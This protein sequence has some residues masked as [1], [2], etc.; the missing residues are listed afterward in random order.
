M[1]DQTVPYK[2]NE[3]SDIYCL[4]VLFWELTS[5][6]FINDLEDNHIALG[7]AVLFTLNHFPWE[8][9]GYQVITSLIINP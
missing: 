3:K 4:G 1:L 7:E 9:Y 8:I 2:L 5:S 6:L